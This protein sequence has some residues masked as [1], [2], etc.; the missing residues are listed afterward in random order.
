MPEK[1]TV[2]RDRN[3]PQIKGAKSSSID[4]MNPDGPRLGI[5]NR[6]D[7]TTKVMPPSPPTLAE[8]YMQPISNSY[9]S[10]LSDCYEIGP[11][12]GILFD[13]R[14]ELRR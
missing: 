5:F 10:D 13:R 2:G 6:P 4:F 7:S 11:D 14:R 9:S 8:V 12:D 1:R 3:V